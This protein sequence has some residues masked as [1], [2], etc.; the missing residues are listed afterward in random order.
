MCWGDCLY[1]WGRCFGYMVVEVLRFFGYC[2]VWC[3]FVSCGIGKGEYGT[4]IQYNIYFGVLF[5]RAGGEVLM[6]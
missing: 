5:L 2:D 4:C 1:S 6:K 3:C